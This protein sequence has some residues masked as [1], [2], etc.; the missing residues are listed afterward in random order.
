MGTP[1]RA[2]VQAVTGERVAALEGIGEMKRE[3]QGKA[4]EAGGSAGRRREPEAGRGARKERERSP[5][6][7]K[8]REMAGP[9]RGRGAEKD[10]GL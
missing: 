1:S 4:V 6:L 5:G 7:A 3:A 2:R 10:L 9:A 8:D